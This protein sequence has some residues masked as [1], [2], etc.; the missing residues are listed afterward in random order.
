MRRSERSASIVTV[1][2][3]DKMYCCLSL[4]GCVQLNSGLSVDAV[5]FVRREPDVTLFSHRLSHRPHF[6]KVAA[7]VSCTS[8]TLDSDDEDMSAIL[9]SSTRLVSN[10]HNTLRNEVLIHR[11]LW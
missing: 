7:Q 5:T 1:V 2:E 10:A 4:V 8:T 6:P 9:R 3:V 11:F